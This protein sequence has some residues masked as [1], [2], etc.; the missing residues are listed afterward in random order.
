MKWRVGAILADVEHLSDIRSMHLALAQDL[1]RFRRW[2]KT[3][4]HWRRPPRRDV[5][6]CIVSVPTTTNDTCCT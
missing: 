1:C 2:S 6:E 4:S 3:K 5:E